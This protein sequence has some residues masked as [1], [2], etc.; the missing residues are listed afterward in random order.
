MKLFQ[1]GK[2][3]RVRV[4]GPF[5]GRGFTT[6]LAALGI[7]PGDVLIVLS[8]APFGGPVLVEAEKTAHRL[9]VGHGIATKLEVEIV[10]ESD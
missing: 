2:G 5:P 1:A 10:D 7:H 4:I 9:A 8:A 6:R 3:Q